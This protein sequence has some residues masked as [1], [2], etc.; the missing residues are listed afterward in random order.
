FARRFAWPT[1]VFNAHEQFKWLRSEGIFEKF[2]DRV[3]KRDTALQ[4]FVNPVS[5][6]NGST[7]EAIQYTGKIES[8]TWKC[9]FKSLVSKEN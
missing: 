8:S 2:R 1:L 6:D 4:G 3:R 9:P 7:S 5:A